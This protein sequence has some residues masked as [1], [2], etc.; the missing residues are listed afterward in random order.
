MEYLNH[1]LQIIQNN[2]CTIPSEVLAKKGEVE[3]GVVVY[4]VENEELKERYNPSPDYFSTWSGSIK[5]EYENSEPIT[6]TDKE[7]IESEI[8]QLQ[9]DVST[10]ETD[11]D[12]LDQTKQDTLV[13]GE[14]IKTINNESLLGSGN[15][16]VITDLSD[17]YT[18]E[19]T[20]TLLD[21]K[22]DK[23][24]MS[25]Y[26]KK[27][28]TY[29]KSEV[30][31]IKTT[32][33]SEIPT[34]TSNLINDSGFIDKSVNNLE[35]YS[36]TSDMNTAIS[37][38]VGIE[39]TNRQNS[40]VALQNQIDAITSS[41][42]VVDVVSTYQDLLDYDTSKLTDKDVIKVM[43]DS[44]HSNA[45]S[46]YRWNTSTF[47]YV[48][49]EG[50]F[51]TKG[52]TD[53]LLNA[54]QNTIDN[55]HKLTSDLV[56]DTNSTNK[57]VT[58]SEKAQ[59][60]TNKTDISNIKDGTTIDSFGDVET[61]LSGKQ[62][63]LTF[64]D[65][66]T[67]NSNNP[68]K[69]GG[70]YNSQQAQDTEII[71]L[72]SIIDQLP[73]ENGTG[74]TITLNNT[75]EAK[76]KSKLSPS[77]MTQETT[78]GKNLL[79]INQIQTQTINGLTIINLGDGTIQINGTANTTTRLDVEYTKELIANTEYKFTNANTRGTGANVNVQ[80]S[81]DNLIGNI[82][83]NVSSQTF[84]PTT[85]QTIAKMRL[86]IDNG[87]TF[88]NYILKAMLIKSTDSETF[89]EFSFGASPSPSY[90]QEI[91]TI[92]GDNVIRDE[93]QNL[94]NIF[95]IKSK[96]P[97]VS[98]DEDGWITISG[99]N[100]GSGSLLY[101][102]L[103]NPKYNLQK[104]KTYR[105][106]L[107]VK[108]VS[109]SGNLTINE[110]NAPQQFITTYSTPFTS[111]SSSHIYYKDITTKS[112]FKDTNQLFTTYA[113]WNAGVSGSITFRLSLLDTTITENEFVYEPYNKTDYPLTLGTLEYSKIG[114]Y[115][116]E[117]IY[118]TTDTNLELNKWYLKKNIEKIIY[119]GSNDEAW[120]QLS[121]TNKFYINIERDLS[122]Y[123][124]MKCN[125][126]TFI[127]AGQS[128]LNNG[129]FACKGGQGTYLWF[130]NDNISSVDNYKTWLSTHNN[131]VELPLA[132]PTYTLL[133]DTLQTQLTNIY[134][135]MM[136]KKGIT[137]IS[138]IND[139]LPVI[140]SASALLDLNTLVGN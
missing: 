51:Y 33:E 38:A 22:Q 83:L 34:K 26:Y 3:L 102:I 28:E 4:E 107:E 104:D 133:N 93:G 30:D 110:A 21:D 129:E 61:A 87:Q 67:Q 70:I 130:R 125:Y 116:D 23:S 111:L 59:I 119:T 106:F 94:L 68:V 55:S 131:I 114:N 45:L 136:S 19:Q 138:Q 17:Y 8:A 122:N 7:Q 112:S 115:E 48:G 27:T 35:N 89:E 25:D 99:N 41:S 40:D 77:E 76:M 103:L 137:N 84:T 121:G 18:K 60:Q 91:H 109:G 120:A 81:S 1:C 78:T 72:N 31:T 127:T 92:T 14:N 140:I 36:K 69:S 98:V 47:D 134:N 62:D 42:D 71:Y 97:N 96:N 118:N 46:Y 108:N 86:Y 113:F 124:N 37:N 135:N 54:K 74:D 2:E 32:I 39:T 12:T 50:P 5:D 75:I 132:T 57:F 63:T 80:D 123:N 128:S 9:Q 52:E 101:N 15:L 10:L 49:S 139:G 64:D 90:P 85:N 105:C 88:S 20:D 66:P 43:Q 44:T 100:T 58:T 56:D 16:E 65:T 73:R 117:F 82:V 24:S 13:S 79:P 53:T 11:I 29:S 6:P 95:D 126:Y